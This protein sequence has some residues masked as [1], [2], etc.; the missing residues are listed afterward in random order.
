MPSR[1]S[2]LRYD[3]RDTRRNLFYVPM[4]VCVLHVRNKNTLHVA[5][6][7]QKT[8]LSETCG[9]EIWMH[10]MT[11]PVIQVCQLQKNTTS[12]AALSHTHNENTARR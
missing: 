8:A 11:C 3:Q 7:T 2:V 12:V 10:E 4:C 6:G 5:V 9:N 1:G